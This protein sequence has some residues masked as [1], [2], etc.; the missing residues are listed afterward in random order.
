VYAWSAQYLIGAHTE[1]MLKRGEISA[2][3]AEAKIEAA[4]Q[5]M[6][7]NYAGRPLYSHALRELGG[8]YLER[9]QAQNAIGYLETFCEEYPEHRWRAKAMYDLAGALKL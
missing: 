4:W 9:G 5:T 8:F 7:D 2:A 6:V 3:E 1:R